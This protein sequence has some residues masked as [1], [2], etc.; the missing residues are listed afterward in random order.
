M[1]GLAAAARKR[2]G[3]APRCVP[4]NFADAMPDRRDAGPHPTRRCFEMLDGRV[5]RRFACGYEDANDLDRTAPMIRL[6]KGFAVRARCP[7]EA[8]GSRWPRNRPSAVWRNCAAR[9]SEGGAAVCSSPLT[10][11]RHHP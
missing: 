5:S 7:Q 9:K 11:F 8:G 3:G 10:Q 4:A 2:R 1:A 6:M